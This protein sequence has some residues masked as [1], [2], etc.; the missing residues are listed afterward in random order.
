MIGRT[1]GFAATCS[2]VANAFLL[3]P[4]IES[5]QDGPSGLSIATLN[6][7]SQVVQLECS[8]CVFPS[9]QEK[10]EDVEAEDGDIVFVAQGGANSLLLNFTITDDGQAMGLNGVNIFP[11]NFDMDLRDLVVAQVPSSASIADVI[12]GRVNSTPLRVSGSGIRVDGAYAASRFG[13]EVVP[14]TFEIMSLENQPMTINEVSIKLLRSKD[15]E[16]MILSAAPVENT[17]GILDALPFPMSDRP[18]RPPP[19]HEDCA[20]LPA[21]LCDW[22]HTIESKIPGH[23][24]G[25]K[26]GGCKGRKDREGH[27]V[28]GH[29]RPHFGSPGME[30]EHDMEMPDM[31]EHD[32]IDKPDMDDRPEHHGLAHDMRPHEPHGPPGRHGPH[33][34]HGPHEHHRGPHGHRMHHHR[35]HHFLHS[36]I[37]GLVAILIP[38]M[39]GI[40]VGM[41]VSLVGLL[42]GRLIGF[43]WITFARGGRRGNASVVLRDDAVE[44]G[45]TEKLLVVDEEATEPLPVYENAPAYEECEKEEK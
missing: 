18:H 23:K 25:G 36:F 29:R 9:T 38:V 35:H 3:P 37:K 19:P 1:V 7:T 5:A 8:S 44:I 14:V 31:E 12:E 39:A 41:F 30:E 33:G 27:R 22:K 34:P 45:E 6:P 2:L 42:V 24:N 28:A 10:V 13:D 20:M 11:P 26:H 4:S 32:G 15:G 21:F 17:A 43:L 16:L 40:T